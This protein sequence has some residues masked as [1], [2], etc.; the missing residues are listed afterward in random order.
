MLY[1]FR[2]HLLYHDINAWMVNVAIQC[3]LSNLKH[4]LYIVVLWPI[5][6]CDC[7]CCVSLVEYLYELFVVQVHCLAAQSLIVLYLCKQ[8]LLSGLQFS[9]YTWFYYHWSCHWIDTRLLRSHHT[10]VF[11][12]LYVY[13][14]ISTCSEDY[15]FSWVV[16]RWCMYYSIQSEELSIDASTILLILVFS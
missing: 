3:T 10:S 2:K 4:F 11:Y 6:D 9:E 16:W 12:A 15:N 14:P 5:R 1:L 7:L 13:I 8:P